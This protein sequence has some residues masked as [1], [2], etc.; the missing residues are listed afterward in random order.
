MKKQ[1][2]FGVVFLLIQV[3]AILYARIIPE[4]FFCWAPYD[5][6]SYYEVYVN[7]EGVELTKN[8]IL[9]R[10][11]YQP[12][13]WEPRSIFNVINIVNQYESTYGKSE[14]AHVKIKYSING[15][16]EQIWIKN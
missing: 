11:H 16:P 14:D 2:V 13:G 3:L 1:Y 4:R 7:I 5:Q 6:H 8:E 15:N 9:E 12:R 10:Y